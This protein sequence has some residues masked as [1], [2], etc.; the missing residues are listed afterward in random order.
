MV[1]LCPG[2]LVTFISPAGIP[3]DFLPDLTPP[4]P[5]PPK[6]VWDS[7]GS[8]ELS[9]ASSEGGFNWMQ[10]PGI[11]KPIKSYVPVQEPS[12]SPVSTPI[13]FT[14]ESTLAGSEISA[15]PVQP[16]GLRLWAAV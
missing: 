13:S 3:S 12:T 5:H 15:E 7:Y 2:A 6:S 9:F 4:Y 16:L 8:G 11:A 1:A 10:R 14:P